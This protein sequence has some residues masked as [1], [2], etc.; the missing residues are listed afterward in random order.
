V[1]GVSKAKRDNPLDN[2]AGAA[3]MSPV[4]IK[5]LGTVGMLLLLLGTRCVMSQETMLQGKLRSSESIMLSYGFPVLPGLTCLC[6]ERV[7]PDRE[8]ANRH[9]TWDALS[10]PLEPGE[11]VKF[12][13][14]ELGDTGFSARGDGGTWRFPVGAKSPDRVLTVL[15]VNE[16]GPHSNCKEHIP[17]GAKSILILSRK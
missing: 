17:A 10:S 1:T 6:Q 16:E 15:T 13:R 9:I 11:V 4:T 2:G 8:D 3:D 12:F 14:R 5:A 7:Y